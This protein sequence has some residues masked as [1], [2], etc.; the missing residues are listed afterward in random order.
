MKSRNYG[1]DFLRIISMFMVVILHILGQGG[2]LKA[3]E[4]MSANYIAGWLFE[5]ASYCAVNIFALISGYVMCHS[6]PRI[7]KLS[8]LWLQ[9]AFYSVSITALFFFLK[10]ETYNSATLLNAFF[11]VTKKQYWYVSAYFGMYL[12][13]PLL[14]TVIKNVSKKTFTL[15]LFSCFFVLSVLPTVLKTDAYGF[16]GGYTLIWLCL[17]YLVGGYMKQFDVVE[18]A[19]RSTGWWLY[20]GSV[21][22]TW[23]FKVGLD[24]ASIRTSETAKYSGMFISYTSPTII[25]AAI[26]IFIGCAKMNFSKISSRLISWF[27]PAALGVYLIHVCPPIWN[28][29]I[30][31]FSAGYAEHTTTKMLLFLFASAMVIYCLCTLIEL[32]RIVL[33]K[34]FRIKA[35]C[36]KLDTAL[37][38]LFGKLYEK[39]FL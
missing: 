29:V 9:V 25:L 35:L 37:T 32:L 27:A 23:L 3:S 31:G 24:Y 20:I 18:R 17:L 21:I 1:I 13:T 34:L 26:G 10:P 30:K 5:I 7:S 36:M 22:L 16:K 11:P 2:I 4:F 19:K 12:L 33:F 28:N 8:E 15:S 6:K 38:N 14:N 39:L